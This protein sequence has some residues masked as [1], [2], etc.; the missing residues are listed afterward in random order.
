MKKLL[1]SLA[2][3]LGMAALVYAG[4]STIPN[5]TALTS[6][7]TDDVLPIEDVSGT[8][9]TKKITVQNLIGTNSDS[10]L[11]ATTLDLSADGNTTIFTVPSG[12]T[13]VLT[14][15]VLVVGAD[16]VSTD[17]T[18]GQAGA[19]TDFLGTQ[20]TDNLDA[21]GD[22]G[23]MAPIPNATPVLQKAYAAGTIIKA[24]VANHAGGATN[25][26]YLFGFLY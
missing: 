18:I 19:L 25:T 7:A 12:K 15:A 23:I 26:L 21:A 1:I 3:I 17:I 13:A 14:K 10:V 9:T 6:T 22:V 11:S 2:F 5:M 4:T 20:Q 16:A 24:V 8:S